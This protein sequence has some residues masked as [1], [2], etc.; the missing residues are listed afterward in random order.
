MRLVS[1]LPQGRLAPAVQTRTWPTAQRNTVVSTATDIG[2]LIRNSAFT[3]G[4]H[5]TGIG[6]SVSLV[7]SRAHNAPVVSPRAGRPSPSRMKRPRSRLLPDRVDN[8]A[9]LPDHDG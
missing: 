7:P 6:R 5:A 2:R 1:A 9:V 3:T 4:A 8:A